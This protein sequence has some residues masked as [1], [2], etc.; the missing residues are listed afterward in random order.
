MREPGSDISTIYL[1]GGTPSQLTT[2]QLRTI[3]YNINNVYR[4]ARDAE[5]TIE[6]N[7]DD[8]TEEYAM[9]IRNMGFKALSLKKEEKR[10]SHMK[11]NVKSFMNIK[12]VN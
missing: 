2:E 3:L 6:C 8:I 5:I 7:P 9:A 1:G 10:N 11:K 4:V 12:K